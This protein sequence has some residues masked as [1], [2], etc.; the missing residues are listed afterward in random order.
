MYPLFLLSYLFSLLFYLFFLF[1]FKKSTQ[2]LLLSW[3]DHCHDLYL[4][5]F[6]SCFKDCYHPL[7]NNFIQTLFSLNKKLASLFLK[8]LSENLS[9]S[10]H[11]LRAKKH[12]EGLNQRP[13]KSH[14]CMPD[15]KMEEKCNKFDDKVRIFD[16]TNLSKKLTSQGL[17]KKLGGISPWWSLL[18][19]FRLLMQLALN[20]RITSNML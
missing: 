3:I 15:N 6:S 13:W 5:L 10:K 14:C 20:S 12:N 1:V 16:E 18:S 11:I 17:W 19:H 4:E 8:F 7:S 9:R 2:L